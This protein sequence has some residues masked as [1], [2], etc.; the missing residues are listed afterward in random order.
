MRYFRRERERRGTVA[1]VLADVSTGWL[2]DLFGAR[3]HPLESSERERWGVLLYGPLEVAL[4]FRLAE[5]E[6]DGVAFELTHG[7]FAAFRYEARVS[8]GAGDAVRVTE[9]IAVA[10]ATVYGGDVVTPWFAR[11]LLPSFVETAP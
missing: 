2:G 7:P 9:T 3:L 10:L 11:S 4:G 1:R 8:P 5:E 6:A